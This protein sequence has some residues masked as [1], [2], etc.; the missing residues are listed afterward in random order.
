MANGL[1][2]VAFT[3]MQ[4]EQA[5]FGRAINVSQGHADG[6]EQAKDF[7]RHDRAAAECEFDARQT[8]LVAERLEH[9]RLR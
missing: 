3:L 5:D 4:G 7:R 8:Q 9:Q 2:I 6:V 1:Q